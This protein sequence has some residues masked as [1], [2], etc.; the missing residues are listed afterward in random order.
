M[1]QDKEGHVLTLRMHPSEVPEDLFRDYVGARYQCVMVRLNSED[2][3]LNREQ[4]YASDYV[5]KAGALCRNPD[6]LRY[7][8]EDLQIM[9]PRE[10]EATEWLRL[11]LDVQSRAEL[12][13]D[14]AARNRLDTIYREFMAW[15]QKS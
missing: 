14:A 11:Y 7:L 12:K 4:E 9:A 8:V 3:P 5:S 10:D 1:K 13:T 6:F 15:N 2:K